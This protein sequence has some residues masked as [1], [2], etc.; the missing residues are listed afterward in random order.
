MTLKCGATEGKKIQAAPYGHLPPSVLYL[1]PP[2]PACRVA[3]PLYGPC[4]WPNIGSIV[5]QWGVSNKHGLSVGH[6]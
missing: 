2:I 5:N 1:T 6:S 4:A 3:V